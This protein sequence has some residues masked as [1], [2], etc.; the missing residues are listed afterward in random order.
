MSTGVS[1]RAFSSKRR[2]TPSA[3]IASRAGLTPRMS[4]QNDP[5][6]SSR[7]TVAF[8]FWNASSEPISSPSTVTRKGKTE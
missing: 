5:L 1:E 6:A 2:E 3:S 8:S 7:V 4:F